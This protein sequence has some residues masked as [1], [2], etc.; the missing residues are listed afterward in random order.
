MSTTGSHAPRK[1]RNTALLGIAALVLMAVVGLS[2]RAWRQYS[3]ANADAAQTSVLIDSVDRFLASLLDAET[4]QRGFLITGDERYLE[5]YNRAIQ[6]IPGQLSAMLRLLAGR[7]GQSAS[8]AR[9][10]ALTADK[11]A[12]LRETIALRRTRGAATPPPIVLSDRGKQ[13]MDE[14]RAICAQIRRT[15]ISSRSQASTQG[16]AAAGTALLVTI[17]A[18]L[19]LL[20]LFAFGLEPFASPDP[21]AQGRS[22]AL[23][24]GAAVLVVV[25]VV[26]FRA[27]LTPLM[28]D[29]SMPFTLFFPAVWFAAWFG[30]LRPG[31][32]SVVLSGLAGAYFFAE[33]TH[34]LLIRYHDDQ[35]ALLML[36][37]V[38][39]G[40]ALLSRSQQR[41]VLRATQAE[42]A[43]RNERQRFET[44]LASIGDAVIATDTQGRVAFANRI[45]LSMLRR[46][47]AEVRGKPLD[48]VFH[49]INEF[50]RAAVESP[51]ARVLRE[52]AIAGLA[53]HTLLIAAD[54]TEAPIDDSA[55]PIRS[56]DRATQ[57]TVLVFRDITERRRAE[58]ASRLLAA[59][60]ES[61]DDA[62]ITKDLNGVMTSWNGGA[63]RIYGYSAEEMIGQ[64]V[65]V[66]APDRPN[67][68]TE[69]LERIKRG[70]GVEHYRTMRRTKAGQ[71]FHM[72]LTVSPLRDASGQITGA[73]TI[74]RDITAEVRAQEEIAEQRER[75][76]VTLG[77]IGDAVL[78]TDAEGR[79][80]YLNPV[81]ERLTGWS[82]EEAAGRP[83]EEIFRI[84]NEESRQTAENPVARVLR[85]GKVVGLANHTLLIARDGKEL[86]IDDSAAP[87]RN[88]RGEMMGVVLTFRDISEKRAAEKLSAMQAAELRKQA[89][90][91]ERVH[92]FI[93]D[94]DD[95]IV[96][97]N[98]GA[99]DLYG[100]SADEAM[101]QVSHTLLRTVF[102]APLA[103]IRAQ[104]I[105]T[106]SWDGELLD[107]V[108]GGGRVY[109]ASHWALH[110]DSDDHPAAILEVDVD[111]TERK[112]AE[113]ELRLSNRALTRAN[114]DLNQFAFAASHDLQ[115]PLRM[116]TSY[117]QL[118]LKGYRGQ[119]DG[120]AA[121]CVAFIT[122]GTQR[123]R[124]LLADLLAYTQLTGAGQ[125]MV[126]FVDL[127][128]VFHATLENC[129]AAIV[130]AAARVTSERLPTVQG[131]EP[132]FVQLFQNLISNA[133][134]Y[135]SEH[136]PRIHVSA[137]LQNGAWRIGV[138]DNGMGIAPEYH[139]QIFGVFKRLHG[140]TIPGTGIGLAICQRVV[141]RY[142]GQIWVESQ[143]DQGATFYF[144]LPA[145]E[146][147]AAHGG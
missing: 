37:I 134:R 84:I 74:G 19:L 29:R 81:A 133:L 102:P 125:E 105:A 49:I 116:I 2:Y 146:G 79:V 85:E 107:T 21:Q 121:T 130:E 118:L 92:C 40:M 93:R 145:V 71:S 41:A 73:S 61:S 7:P 65:S 100:F 78:A 54:G 97:W 76:R 5:P 80:A 77:S 60:V 3:R 126:A 9:L 131:Y 17:A 91:L 70:E 69:I 6:K 68:M 141:E 27:A 111:I 114:E 106:G 34:S 59:V 115:E 140:K 62:I 109:V 57:G 14:I 112:Q 18:A 128:G 35:V 127:N 46:P 103:D 26:L 108:R 23:R 98:P 33:P 56:G 1:G 83:L 99:A 47:E 110:K 63:E 58:A 13:T 124:E 25:L 39:F 43:E 138:K 45:A 75:L 123:M 72:S 90:L 143:V 32:V 104:L 28:G 142:G 42:T 10:N 135:R 38:G 30:G 113:Q 136:P 86:A 16:E 44:T 36:V 50:T 15:E 119:L 94:L 51:V 101:G 53:N 139:Q 87:M 137:V 52:G 88:V 82:S 4:G 66:L 67:E 22:P 11:L 147:A 89:R 8:A 12:E 64:P 48:E 132:H 24:Y 144:T 20:F 31:V 129:Q 96:F 122:E 117:S 120:E 95:R 55:A